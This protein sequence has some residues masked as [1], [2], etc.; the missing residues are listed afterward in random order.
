[1]DTVPGAHVPSLMLTLRSREE[2]Q[3]YVL[4]ENSQKTNVP[5]GGSLLELPSFARKMQRL[6]SHQSASLWKSVT[7]PVAHGLPH[8]AQNSLQIVSQRN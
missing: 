2:H 3:L 6:S 7:S 4:L 8:T 1:M 5:I